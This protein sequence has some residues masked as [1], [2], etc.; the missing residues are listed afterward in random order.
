MV[1]STEEF[2]TMMEAAARGARS[3]LRA[4]E[5]AEDAV[6]EALMR[7]FVRWTEGRA[8]TD[9]EGWMYRVGKNEARRWLARERRAKRS[10]LP[11]EV[12]VEVC[13]VEGD[14]GLLMRWTGHAVLDAF[15][16]LLTARQREVVRAAIEP[17]ISMH[18]AARRVGMDRSTFRRALNRAGGRIRRRVDLSPVPGHWA[19][20]E[21]S[22]RGHDSPVDASA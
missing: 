12:L 6:Q 22:R 16:S 18:E 10:E 4:G 14:A 15:G 1:E 3:V 5:G 13:A 20:P 21:R 2:R 11:A 19:G 17:G 9:H 8:P 7:W